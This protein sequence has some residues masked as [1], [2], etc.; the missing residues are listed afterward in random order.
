[1]TLRTAG[2]HHV[3]AFV[4]DAQANVDFYAGIL[5]LRLV[6]QTVNFDVPSVYHL[7]FGN[8]TGAPGT[9]VTFFPFE[10]GRQGKIGSG[11]VEWITFAIPEGAMSFWEN[12]LTRFGIEFTRERR[13]EETYLRF[14]DRDGLQLELT[15]RREGPDSRWSFGE[16]PAE[17][18][19]KGLG[20]AVLNSGAP[21][22][23]GILLQELLGL[24][25]VGRENGLLRFRSYGELGN[26]IELKEAASDLGHGGPG[27]VHHIAWRAK[28]DAEHEVW[29]ERIVNRGLEPTPVK[30]RNYF[31]AIYFYEPGG[32]FFE[33][34][35]DS[36]GFDR[37]ESYE[38]LGQALKLPEWYE[39]RRSDIVKGLP[40]FIVR[41]FEED[42]SG[43]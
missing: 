7:Y 8:E 39:E 33:I 12:R 27:T 2:I 26:I 23:T 29:R 34:A 28:N 19:I 3:T 41:P 38:E 20:G 10:H 17:K 1:M 14:A 22:R 36:P 18:A 11:Q 16:I 35:T 30:D 4:R 5:G 24:E 42:K 32:I 40:A 15:E 25:K 21:E 9:V 43:D 6:K 31:N 13:F 37:D